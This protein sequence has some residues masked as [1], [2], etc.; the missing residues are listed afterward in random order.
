TTY[1][2]DALD[3]LTTV[4]QDSELGGLTTATTY[5]AGGKTKVVDPRGHATTTSYK[6]YDQ[7]SL[8]W[9]VAIAHPGGAYTDIERD[10]FGKP[11]SI[12]K[13]NAAS[14]VNLTRNY[15]Y[16]SAQELCASVEPET[17]TKKYSYDGAGNLVRE[18]FRMPVSL[19]A[20]CM[21][22]LAL[23]GPPPTGGSN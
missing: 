13:R 3:R 12:T 8:E 23:G 5:Q 21:S 1:S 10:A 16:N 2:H 11:L 6:A 22:T 7:P 9:P 18:V 17:G 14:T 15:A 4:K 19:P 20:S